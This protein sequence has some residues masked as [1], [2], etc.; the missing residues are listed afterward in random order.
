MKK[1]IHFKLTLLLVIF[2]PD[3]VFA[4]PEI[5]NSNN[6][7]AAKGVR[8]GSFEIRPVL[9]LGS[10]W[11][12]NIYN[13]KQNVVGAF[14]THIT[15]SV[16]IAS[17]WNR[18][19][20]DLNVLSDIQNYVDH[21]H[22]DR[23]IVNVTL[24][25][26]LDVVRESFAYTH[27]GYL[28]SP[29]QRGAPDS[30]VNAL[31]P[32]GSQISTAEV[33]YDHKTHRIRLHADNI[34][35]MMKFADGMTGLGSVIPNNQNRSRL[36]NFSTIRAG[37]E[38]TPNYEAFLQ[39]TY[40]FINYDYKYDQWGYQRSSTGYKAVAGVALEL[41]GKLIGN[42]RIGYQGQF[43][44][45]PRLKPAEGLAGGVTLSWT[46]TG[47]T[48][49][50]VDL[51]RTIAQTTQLGASGF[52]ATVFTAT[53]E[54]E[55]LRNLLLSS[56][57]GYSYNQYIG[58]NFPNPARTEDVYLA[59]IK[60]KYLLNRYFFANVGYLYNSRSV[61]NVSNVNYDANLYYIGIGTQ[62]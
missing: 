58:G 13:N 60:A 6:D 57:A 35:A 14:V 24:N 51:T 29:E 10:D 49:A 34:T 19:F 62:F 17:N 33:G 48:T 56:T 61:Q 26:R 31:R 7:Y 4:L 41:S 37:Y 55:L 11:N 3:C 9:R 27:L 53:V 54:H 12:T 15:P 1:K 40:N 2:L 8:V 45:D 44:D 47:L 21:P 50:T 36:E 22:E 23:Q 18:H 28:N 5:T 25:G 16:N 32:T 20:I 43:Y 38:I 39:G 59:G 30:P 52:F 46:P 42:A